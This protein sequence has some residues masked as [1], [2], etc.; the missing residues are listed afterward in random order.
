MRSALDRVGVRYAYVDIRQDEA[1]RA[2]VR[3]INAGCESVPTLVF[4]DGSTLTEPS[5]HALNLKLGL[6]EDTPG[7]SSR[8]AVFEIRPFMLVL[9][10]IGV[11]GVGI[12]LILQIQAVELVG[13]LCLVGGLGLWVARRTV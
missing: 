8:P 7:L 10:A 4:P 2:R 13:G 1:G 6:D 5:P 11:V 3:E 9:G 12:G